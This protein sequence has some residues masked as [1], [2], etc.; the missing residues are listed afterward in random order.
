MVICNGFCSAQIPEKPAK[1]DKWSYTEK[2]AWRGKN[3]DPRI[4]YGLYVDKLKV[5]EIMQDS[6]LVAKVL[7]ATDDP[8][9][10]SVESLPDRY[11]MKANN[12]SGRGLLVKD[13]M[14]LA[15]CKGESDFV[16]VPATAENLRSYAN[17]W[18]TIPYRDEKEMQYSLVKPMI[19]FEEY[20]DQHH[21]DINL[22]CFY[23]K[24]KLIVIFFIDE[25]Q[26]KPVLS[27][28]DSDWNIIEASHSKYQ[29][30][31]KKIEEPAWL[32]KLIAYTEQLTQHIDHVRVDYFLSGNDIYFG[33]FTFTTGVK[34][35]RFHPKS[36]KYVLGSYWKYP[37]EK[38][39]MKNFGELVKGKL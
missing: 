22:F 3:L 15:S 6:I 18:L 30:V 21:T 17:D 10:I 35:L 32:K 5:K 27:W 20:L 13:G 7:F 2:I 38:K 11:F 9:A 23:G 39:S 25:Y 34:G 31:N 37:K 29:T 28:Y 24:V 12:A 33:E 26:K 8:S 14:I 19:L 4:P 36:Y 16:P 1:W